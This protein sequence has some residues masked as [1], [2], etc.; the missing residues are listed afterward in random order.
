MILDISVNLVSFLTSASL[1]VIEGQERRNYAT[2]KDIKEK[3]SK[4]A[5]LWTP[6]KS[7]IKGGYKHDKS[8]RMAP[9]DGYN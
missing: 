6:A 4:V 3:Q 5:P 1:Y 2:V 8:I 7:I 9:E